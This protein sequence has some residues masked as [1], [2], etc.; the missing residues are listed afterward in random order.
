MYGFHK[1]ILIYLFFDIRHPKRLTVCDVFQTGSPETPLWEFKHGNGNFKRGDLGGLREI[2]RRAS[3]VALPHR[4]SIAAVPKTAKSHIISPLEAGPDS[5]GIRMNMLEHSLY[6][7]H[8]RLARTED[9]QAFMISKCQSLSDG[10]VK[11]YQ[12][13][14]SVLRLACAY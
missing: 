3:K 7:M 11:C 4:D 13:H 5:S 10:L 2:K 9:A 6:D 14:S 1:G 12:V 8:A